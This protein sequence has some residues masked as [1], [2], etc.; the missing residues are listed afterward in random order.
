MATTADFKNG[1]YISFNGKPC[2]I[3]WFQHVKPGKGGAFVKTKLRNLENGRVLENTFNAGE[4]VETIRVERR[5][6]QFLY[7]DDMGYNFMHTETFE[8]I[9]LQPDLVENSDLMK[10]GQYVEMMFLA[11][12]ERVLTCELPPFVEMEITYTEPA[13]KGDTAST[14]ALKAATLETGA[15]IMVPLFINQGERIKVDTRT[16][17]YSERVK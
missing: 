15:Q 7:K 12:E 16:R 9:S 2:S 14:N 10:E 6:Y 17:G 1:M 8:Q 4:K 3:I 5:P 11:D 13:V